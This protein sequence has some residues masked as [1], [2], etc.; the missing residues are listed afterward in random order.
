MF[1]KK[2]RSENGGHDPDLRKSGRVPRS[3]SVAAAA[4]AETAPAAR[5]VGAEA[6]G[7]ARAPDSFIRL[8]QNGVGRYA[9]SPLFPINK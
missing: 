3:R 8:E 1:P 2:D 7:L 4:A 9:P 6:A 5:P